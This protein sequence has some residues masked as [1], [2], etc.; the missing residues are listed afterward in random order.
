M[1]VSGSGHSD[2]ADVA[3]I[4]ASGRVGVPV[5]EHLA[6]ERPAGEPPAGIRPAYTEH[7]TRYEERTGPY[8][9][10][11]RRLVDLLP[12]R[13]GDTVLDVGCGT[14]LCFPM[15]RDKVGPS[16]LIV[17]IDESPDMLAMARR[18]VEEGGHRGVELIASPIEQAEIPV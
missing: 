4:E 10:W 13:P 14:G 9:E 5:R 15:L 7:A 8:Q 11:R 12:L 6:G 1:L 18:H 2:G 17:G 16:G 3:V